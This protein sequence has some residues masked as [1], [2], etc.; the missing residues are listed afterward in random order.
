VQTIGAVAL[1]ATTDEAIIIGL[2]SLKWA[3]V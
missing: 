3:I 2:S 1:D